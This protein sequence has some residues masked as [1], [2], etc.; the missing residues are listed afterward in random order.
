M[1]FFL[2]PVYGI[3]DCAAHAEPGSDCLYKGHDGIRNIDSGKSYVPQTV[4]HE[5]AV[6]NRINAG[7]GERQDRRENIFEKCFRITHLYHGYSYLRLLEK[8]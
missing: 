6:Y 5:K 3:I 4:F 8:V 1:F 2:C 7:Q